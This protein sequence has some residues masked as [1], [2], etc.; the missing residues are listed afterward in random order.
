MRLYFLGTTLSTVGDYALWLAAGVWVKELTGSTA[1]AG[2]CMLALILG[3][4]LSPVAGYVADSMRRKPLLLATNAVTGLLVLALTQV[5]GAG[6]VW[7]IYAVMFVNGLAVSLT[8][9]ATT[10]LLPRLVAPEQL[11]AANGLTQALTQGQRLI[12]PALGI[13]LL[14][15]FGGGVVAAIDAASFAV[16]FLCWA[17]IKVDDPRPRPT[18]LNW[19]QETTAGFGF[20]LRTPSLRQLTGAMVLGLFVI[21]MFETLSLAVTTVGLHRAPTWVGVLVTVMGVSGIL[22]GLLAGRLLT[23]LGAGRLTALG[24]ALFGVGALGMAVPMTAVVVAAALLF[25]FGLPCIIVGAIT[26][27]QLTTPNEL[28]GRVSGARAFAITAGQA[29]GMAAGSALISVV[30][31]RDIAYAAAALLT[32]SALYLFTRREQHPA[33]APAS[34]EETAEQ[35]TAAETAA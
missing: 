30:F 24:L 1:Q 3:T 21:G 20:L 4:L 19:R 6:D 28:L 8:D 10:A 23:P 2:L 29:L 34:A 5:H 27:L 14:A 7:L 17:F 25:G 13:G 12:T 35:E 15:A 9:S 18:E 22:S 11:G 31:Y 16:G 32:L 33:G 26:A